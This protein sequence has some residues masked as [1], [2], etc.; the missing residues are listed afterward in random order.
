MV[1]ANDEMIAPD[2]VQV[3]RTLQKS[4]EKL[5]SVQD[6]LAGQIAAL[7]AIEYQ[8]RILALRESSRSIN[9]HADLDELRYLCQLQE[10]TNANFR[11]MRK[12]Y[13]DLTAQI[14]MLMEQHEWLYDATFAQGGG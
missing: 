7:N 13:A 14:D 11:Q 5:M 3:R 10:E 2:V 1:S 4:L 6:Y 12:S 8:V 9:D